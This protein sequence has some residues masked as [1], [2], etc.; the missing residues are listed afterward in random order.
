M[1]RI[2]LHRPARAMPPS[3]PDEPV[4]LPTVPQQHQGSYG[5]SGLATILL[6]VMSSVALASYMIINGNPLLIIVGLSFVVCS[7]GGIALIGHRM[8]NASTKTSDRQRTRY[9]EHLIEV[10]EAARQVAA[11]Q[12]LSAGW[13]HPSPERLWAIAR[14]RRRVWERRPTDPDFL[15]VR[16]GIGDGPLATP[17]AMSTQQDPMAEYDEEILAMANRHVDLLGTVG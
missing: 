6:P 13:V 14:R 12:R 1:T 9:R 11:V 16:V 10:R 5:G 8:R 2:S 3:V 7:V 4:R 17:V 15:H